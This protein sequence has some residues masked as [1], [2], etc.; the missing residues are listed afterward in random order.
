MLASGSES[1]TLRT[2]ATGSE[3]GTLR[4]LATGSELETLRTLA[5]GSEL[6]TLRTLATG[7]ELGTLRT[8][9]TGSECYKGATGFIDPRIILCF[10]WGCTEK[11]ARFRVVQRL[12]NSTSAVA[13]GSECSNREWRSLPVR[14]L[15]LG[16]SSDAKTP[17]AQSLLVASFSVRVCFFSLAGSPQKALTREFKRPSKAFQFS[18]IPFI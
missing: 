10:R 7:S 5:T 1:G 12:Q 18:T 9:A 4:T 11:N 13:T 16:W 15:N 14:T 8:L 3:L 2:L 17:Q 6:G